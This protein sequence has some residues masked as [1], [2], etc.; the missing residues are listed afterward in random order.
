[1]RDSPG[2]GAIFAL[3]GL[4]GLSILSRTTV[5]ARGIRGHCS[6]GAQKLAERMLKESVQMGHLAIQDSNILMAAV[7]ASE[8]AKLA[9]IAKD[10]CDTYSLPAKLRE[11]ALETL[12]L[13]RDNKATLV[14]AIIEDAS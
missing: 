9:A 2:G 7:H 6:S 4:L 3:G 1:M 12:E 5:D 10:L 13:C 11:Q 14:S 8:A